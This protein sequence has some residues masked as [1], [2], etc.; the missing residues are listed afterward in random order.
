MSQ[1]TAMLAI[2]TEAVICSDR[3]AGAAV[4]TRV[5]LHAKVHTQSSCVRGLGFQTAV[6]GRRGMPL[7]EVMQTERPLLLQINS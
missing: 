6:P 3:P 2:S 7:Q 1:T 4:D 5:N